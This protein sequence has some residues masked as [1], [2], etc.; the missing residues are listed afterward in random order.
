MRSRSRATPVSRTGCCGIRRT[1]ATS[2]ALTRSSSGSDAP[3]RVPRRVGVRSAGRY[4][5]GQ[6]HPGTGLSR[7]PRRHRRRRLCGQLLRAAPAQPQPTPRSHAD[8]RS[9]YFRPLSMSDSVV[10]GQRA[11]AAITVGRNALVQA[12]V[13]FVPDVVTAIDPARQRVQLRSGAAL[14]YDKAV[15][16]PGIRLLFGTPEGYDEAATLLMPHAWQA[17]AQTQLL[18]A[19]LRATAY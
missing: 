16:A 17:G 6:G 8:R 14:D 15:L 19:Q 11:L 18:A 4:C 12:G 13:R 7:R 2:P 5:A 9:R 10:T 1:R 3:A